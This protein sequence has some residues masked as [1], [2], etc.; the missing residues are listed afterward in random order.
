[1]SDISATLDPISTLIHDLSGILDQE[2]ERLAA[3]LTLLQQEQQSIQTLSLGGL[4]A[5]HETKLAVLS[6]LQALESRRV[7]AVGRLA[8]RW[9][10][11]VAGLT[12]QAIAARLSPPE[13]GRLLRQQDRLNA[14]VLALRDAGTL[15]DLLLSGSI[16]FIEQ[17]LS[18]WRGG[19]PAPVYSPA[20]MLQPAAAG[21]AY[22]A[23]KG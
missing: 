11:E 13:A 6:E 14:A 10:T 4:N 7:E 20:G 17:C 21:G 5:V 15:T 1:M 22:L 9:E 12:L 16:A 18:L 19:A 23:R 3:L 2:Q 8:E